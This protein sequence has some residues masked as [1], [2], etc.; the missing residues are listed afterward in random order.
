MS[1]AAVEA[2]QEEAD[3]SGSLRLS[4]TLPR[5]TTAGQNGRKYQGPVAVDDEDA[6]PS[7]EDR[8]PGVKKQVPSI[9]DMAV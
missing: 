7:Q 6:V 5:R 1:A 9:R 4:S 2:F 8:P 3:I